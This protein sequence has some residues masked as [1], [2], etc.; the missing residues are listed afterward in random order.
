MGEVRVENTQYGFRFGA[1]M[2][3]RLFTLDGRVC[4]EITTDAGKSIQVYVSAAGRSLRVFGDGEWTGEPQ[5]VANTA[6][7][8]TAG[9]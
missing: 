2:V 4:V 3:T 1:M 9:A 7:G 6:A 5:R 8:E